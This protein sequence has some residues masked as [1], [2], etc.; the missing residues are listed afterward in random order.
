V[1]QIRVAISGELQDVLGVLDDAASWLQSIGVT[2][3][4]P[5]S[6]SAD[7]AWVT[8][9]ERWTADGNVYIAR[10]DDGSAV[11]CFRLML[12]DDHIWQAQPAKALYLHSLAVTRLSAGQG[13]ARHLLDSALEIARANGVDE[14]RL[15]C[16]A[17]NE[18]LRRYY[19]DAGFEFRGETEVDDDGSRYWVA[20]FAKTVR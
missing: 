4:W 7:P 10:D 14:L 8:R 5:P 12:S 2:E 13:I 19:I 1:L 3:Q 15:D 20:R 16:W 17:G 6:F 9:F 11:G 18:R